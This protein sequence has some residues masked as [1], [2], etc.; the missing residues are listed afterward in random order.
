MNSRIDDLYTEVVFDYT[1]AKNDL[2]NIQRKITVVLKDDYGGRNEQQR[3]AAAYKRARN[4]PV[5]FDEEGNPTAF[6]NLFEVEAALRRRA[7]LLEAIM[8]VLQQ[9]SERLISDL[10]VLK[11][12]GRVV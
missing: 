6:V 12:E 2:E 1:M 8:K 3:T 5:E 11:L 7:M 10:A 9:K 4:F